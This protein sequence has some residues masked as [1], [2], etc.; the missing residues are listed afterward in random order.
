VTQPSC[1]FHYS[2]YKLDSASETRAW[3]A[4]VGTVVSYGISSDSNEVE[5]EIPSTLGG[6]D[7]SLEAPASDDV[8]DAL[9][10]EFELTFG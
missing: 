1:H 7:L 4:T 2:P 3:V 10:P 5:V 9:P 6:E 8:R